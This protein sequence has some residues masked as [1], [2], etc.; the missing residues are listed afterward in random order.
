M[1][2]SPNSQDYDKTIP[3]NLGYC[4][5]DSMDMC[6]VLAVICHISRRSTQVS[7][8]EPLQITSFKVV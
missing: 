6:L 2:P 1:P 8:L 3:Q 4:G 5:M 7:L